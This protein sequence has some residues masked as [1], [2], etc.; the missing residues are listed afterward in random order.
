MATTDRESDKFVLRLPDGMRALIAEAAKA[1]GR[2]MN[3]EIVSRLESSFEPRSYTITFDA[4]VPPEKADE[5]ELATLEAAQRSG[6]SVLLRLP[7]YWVEGA[8]PPQFT[9][10]DLKGA[11][12]KS[13]DVLARDPL[14]G[15]G[16]KP[17]KRRGRP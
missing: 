11:F 6:G 7:A 8:E 4:S 5:I 12:A 10:A 17:K 13:I 16:P 14:E 2:S 1:S 9:G 15:K 3:A